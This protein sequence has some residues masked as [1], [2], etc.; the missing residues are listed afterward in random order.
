[1]PDEIVTETSRVKLSGRA[2]WLMSVAETELGRSQIETCPAPENNLSKK[3][4][5]RF[6]K[7][8]ASLG[9]R[10]SRPYMVVV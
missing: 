7:E 9:F 2:E 10:V 5:V 1:M 3:D 4:V 6:L 8:L